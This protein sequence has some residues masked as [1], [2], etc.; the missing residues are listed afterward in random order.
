[1]E[2][3]YVLA[4]NLKESKFEDIFY[5]QCERTTTKAL[6]QKTNLNFLN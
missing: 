1:M 3:H 4:D 6:K 2:D 5:L